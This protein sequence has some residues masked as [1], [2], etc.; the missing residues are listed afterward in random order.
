MFRSDVYHYRIN[1][2]ICRDINECEE[3]AVV[4]YAVYTIIA[5]PFRSAETLMSVRRRPIVF[6]TH[7]VETHL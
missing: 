7:S 1:F 2:Q 4:R 3:Q 6:R 5:L